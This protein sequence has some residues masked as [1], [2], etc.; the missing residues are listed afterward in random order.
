MITIHETTTIHSLIKA[1]D[2]A[3]TDAYDR[4]Y[5]S[6]WVFPVSVYELPS[7]DTLENPVY[8]YSGLQ[9]FV[10]APS[11]GP[12]ILKAIKRA[13]ALSGILVPGFG[14]SMAERHSSAARASIRGLDAILTE[15]GVPREDGPLRI[16]TALGDRRLVDEYLAEIYGD[17]G[18]RPLKLAQLPRYCFA[19]L[20]DRAV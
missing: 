15:A 2:T 16:A 7:T 19:G 18:D 17:E 6:T 12:Q 10:L 14:D 5:A 8:V 11:N 9:I 4:G 3:Y 13:R 20:E 1:D